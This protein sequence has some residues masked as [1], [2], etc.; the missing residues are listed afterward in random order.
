MK[1]IFHFIL[2]FGI[3]YGL[4][5]GSASHARA[6][7]ETE[8][9]SAAPE[10]SSEC[11]T[12]TEITFTAASDY[13]EHAAFYDVRLDVEFT[14]ER[15]T[16]LVIPAFWD[17]GKTWRVRFAPTET[18]VWKYVTR[19][20]IPSDSGLDAQTGRVKC[21]PYTGDYE[22]YKRGFI[23]VRDGLK[24]FVYADG[25]PFFYLG[26]THWG[27]M[28]EEFDV[29][30]PHAG[31]IRTDSHFKYVV[32]RRSEQG[33][34]VFQSEPIGTSVNY[35]DGISSED[36]KGFQN[37]DRYFRH[38]ADRGLV[39]ANAQFF[40]PSEMVPIQSDDA[41]L[42]LITRYWVARYGAYP[43]LWT[44]GQETD[45]N[46]YKKFPDD[47][48]YVKVCHWIHMYDAYRHPMTAHME[49]AGVT[50]RSGINGTHASRFQDV[51][52][53]T[54]YGVQWSH[55]LNAKFNTGVPKDFWN[56][57]KGK[58]S[59]L[60]ESL[61][62]NLWTKDF[63]ARAEGWL[64]FLNGF[65]GY[66]YGAADLWLYQSTY[67]MKTTST[68]DGVSTV[69]PEDKAM[70]WCDALELASA[71]QT[72][73]MKTFLQAHSWWK[74]VPEFASDTPFFSP[75]SDAVFHMAAHDSTELYVLYFYSKTKETG[76]MQT[77]SPAAPYTFTWFNPRTGETHSE[78]AIHAESASDGTYELPGKPDDEDWVLVVQKS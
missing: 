45:Y 39:H 59:I 48:P 46:F 30:G 28:K 15:G 44:L 67:D 43:V 71:R 47:N 54:W 11:W 52:G 49:N 20:N 74:L 23:T 12:A 73:F 22:I 66:G 53:H 55:R 26:D 4:P 51:P 40:Y 70:F 33:F 10:S 9:R 38:I 77:L 35:S 27:M 61:Y 13:T 1:I 37:M 17:G 25:T 6:S 18:G 50:T 78:T 19:C 68:H 60:Y 29:P 75:A 76:K 16:V 56:D 36:V 62:C 14:S 8:S 24:Y 34:T 21:V 3:I 57:G 42:E 58:V 2:F 5:F 31:N 63:G 64:A 41:F 32:N 7:E 72:G 69:T 65:Y